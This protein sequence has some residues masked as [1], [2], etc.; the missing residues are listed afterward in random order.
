MHKQCCPRAPLAAKERGRARRLAA[1]AT[2]QG[3]AARSNRNVAGQG[4]SQHQQR[5]RA[6][7]LTAASMWQGRAAHSNING[8]G[9]GGSQHVVEVGRNVGDG[10]GGVARHHHLGRSAVML[11]KGLQAPSR[12]AQGSSQMCC[13]ALH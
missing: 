5:A 11:Y 4:G 12:G 13:Q 8:G 3:R 2:E 7:R 6:W 10:E 1:T 9:Q